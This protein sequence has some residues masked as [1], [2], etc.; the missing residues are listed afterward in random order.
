MSDCYLLSRESVERF[1]RPGT[2]GNY[3]L[4]D[5]SQSIRYVG[6]SDTDLQQRLFDH[7]NEKP[8][9]YYKC[10]PA[11]SPEEAYYKECEQYHQHLGSGKL[12][13]K[14]HPATPDGTELRCP[15]FWC[16]F[17]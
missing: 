6:R 3:I 11:S 4:Y 17:N 15:I 14:Y 5:V 2:P 1:V 13:N 16:E 7:V 10:W 8:Y 12:L 9:Q